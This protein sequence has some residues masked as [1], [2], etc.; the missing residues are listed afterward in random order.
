MAEEKVVPTGPKGA[1]RT[2]DDDSQ[3]YPHVGSEP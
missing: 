1:V 2:S 3:A